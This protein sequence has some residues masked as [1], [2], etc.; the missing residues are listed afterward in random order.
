MGLF[1]ISS[2]MLLPGCKPAAWRGQTFFIPDVSTEMGRRI[3]VTYFPGLDD[4]AIEDLGAAMG[5]I[6]GR[7]LIVGDEYVQQAL[8]LQAAFMAPGPGTFLHPWIGEL[9]V[10]VPPGAASVSFSAVELRV[11]RFEV[12]FQPVPAFGPWG[13]RAS[14]PIISTFSRLI[15]TVSSL[16]WTARGFG[17]IGISGGAVVGTATWSAMTETATD[18][19][20]VVSDLCAEVPGAPVFGPAVVPSAAAGKTAVTL[21]ARAGAGTTR[22][23]VPSRTSPRSYPPG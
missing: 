4:P 15:G 19:A 20:T 1:D 13:G 16:L 14:V 8:M 3:V 7:G 12:T 10:I 18:C 17:A 23:R 9:T 2:G 21:A 6:R 11:V 5:P 22:G